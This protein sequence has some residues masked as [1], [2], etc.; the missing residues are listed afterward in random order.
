MPGGSNLRFGITDM[1]HGLKSLSE[2][3]WIIFTYITH[4]STVSKV[5]HH[6]NQHALKHE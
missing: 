5:H 4:K 2:K 3:W 6:A 1:G